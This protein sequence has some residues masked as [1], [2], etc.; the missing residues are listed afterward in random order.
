LKN[1]LLCLIMFLLLWVYSFSSN[2]IFI[3]NR[4]MIGNELIFNVPDDNNDYKWEIENKP[5]FSQTFLKEY[6]GKISFIPDIPGNYEFILYK[7]GEKYSEKKLTVIGNTNDS[8]KTLINNFNNYYNSKNLYMVLYTSQMITQNYS[9][10]YYIKEMYS[11]IVNL[12]F[13]IGN[14]ETAK[15]YINKI[16][17]RYKMSN[18]ESIGYLY[19][20]YIIYDSLNNKKK[21]LEIIDEI[22]AIDEEFILKFSNENIIKNNIKYIGIL[23]RYYEKTHNREVASILGDYHFENKEYCQAELYYRNADKIKL[24]K[25]YAHTD[26]ED[27]IDELMETLQDDEKI[28]VQKFISEYR[29]KERDSN[30]YKTAEENYKNYKF[31]IAELYYNRIIK[32]SHNKELQNEVM[33]KLAKLYFTEKKYNLSKEYF[34]KYLNNYENEGLLIDCLYHLGVIYFETNKL[35]ESEKYFDEIIKNYP[36][37]LWETKASIY[38]IKIKNK[39]EQN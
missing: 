34:E 25:L 22:I 17:Y 11:K 35:D 30:Y 15:D 33:Y 16:L 8:E 23:K 7:N 37:T 5:F 38:K 19:K 31:E 29:T 27:K 20:L 4:I 1:K 3:E 10:S 13:E 6:D 14:Y 24:F 12:S 2:N 28:E 18:E 26:N 36:L 39:K 32:E 21:Q 9:N